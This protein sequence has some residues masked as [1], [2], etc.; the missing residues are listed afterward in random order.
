MAK[1]TS[2]NN[3]TLGLIAF[4]V[5]AVTGL[6]LLITAIIEYAG[7]SV[8]LG[9]YVNVLVQIALYVVVAWVSF[10]YV[11]KKQVWMKVVYWISIAV[12]AIAIILPLLNEIF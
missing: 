8:D 11:S 7:G 1:K 6:G 10:A 2:S 3:Q 9:E 12:I 5:L 4:I